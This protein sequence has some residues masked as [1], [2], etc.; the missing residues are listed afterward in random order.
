[1][2]SQKSESG[3]VQLVS[4]RKS[5]GWWIV[6]LA[7]R[8]PD[9]GPYGTRREADEDRQGLTAFARRHPTYV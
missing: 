7:G 3:E 1:M 5:D 4:R 8:M 9:H 6:D 2:S